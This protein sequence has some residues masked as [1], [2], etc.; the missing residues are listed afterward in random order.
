MGMAFSG[1]T[2]LAYSSSEQE[3]IC[4]YHETCNGYCRCIISRLD[5]KIGRWTADVETDQIYIAMEGWR[6][7]SGDWID[8]YRFNADATIVDNIYDEATGQ[9][10]IY[11]PPFR[12]PV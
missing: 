6:Q 10:R 12:I 2:L 7:V 5:Y 4:T 8:Y 1:Y 11:S 9:G 3:A